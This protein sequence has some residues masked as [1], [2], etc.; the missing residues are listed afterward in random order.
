MTSCPFALSQKY[1]LIKRERIGSPEY[2]SCLS[3]YM[4]SE[5]R[6]DGLCQNMNDVY[7]VFEQNLRLINEIIDINNIRNC[8]RI[9]IDTT[10][11]CNMA[12]FDDGVL[13]AETLEN[14]LY[15]LGSLFDTWEID[16]KNKTD[17]IKVVSRQIEDILNNYKSDER[18]LYKTLKKMR[19]EVTKFQLMWENLAVKKEESEK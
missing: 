19:F 15:D 1:I 14:V 2:L 3:C 12:D 4:K 7:G 17:I 10:I 8:F 9:A 13:I 6:T 11:F 5:D 16:D 18:K